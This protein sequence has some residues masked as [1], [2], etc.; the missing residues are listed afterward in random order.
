MEQFLV[1][2]ILYGKVNE[3]IF[4][5]EKRAHQVKRLIHN[6]HGIPVMVSPYEN[7]L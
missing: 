2:F 1:T 4:D 3:W 5:D 7:L 6:R